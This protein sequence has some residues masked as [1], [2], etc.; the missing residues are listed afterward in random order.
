[1]LECVEQMLIQF[2]DIL[3]VFIPLY[4]IFDIAGDLLFKNSQKGVLFMIYVPENNTYNKCYV[5]Q[6]SDIIRAY[7]RVPSN[8][9]NY[10]YRDYYIKSN[11][12]Y[13]D[14]TGSW[15]QYAALPICLTSFI[16]LTVS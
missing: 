8:N 16:L 9:T 11:Y 6:N 12:I 4:C 15:S 13:K 14:G 3:K 5:V 7:D 10:N 1:M 2:V